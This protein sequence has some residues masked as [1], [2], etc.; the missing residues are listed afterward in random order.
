MHNASLPVRL[1]LLPIDL[2]RTVILAVRISL[3]HL[4]VILRSTILRLPAVHAFCHAERLT[5]GDFRI[6]ACPFARKFGNPAL[7]TMLCSYCRLTDRMGTKRI[8]VCHRRGG[9]PASAITHILFGVLPVLA[10]LAA[11]FWILRPG[12]GMLEETQRLLHPSDP[13][14]APLHGPPAASPDP[15]SPPDAST[16]DGAPS[17]PT[18]ASDEEGDI[19]VLPPLLR[20][21]HTAPG[22][23]ERRPPLMGST[24]QERRR[25]VEASASPAKATVTRPLRVDKIR[26]LKQAR[27]AARNGDHASAL[28]LAQQAIADGE[29]SATARLLVARSEL[30]CG[31][32]G[33][34]LASAKR[35]LQLDPRSAEAHAIVGEVFLGQGSTGLAQKS[36]QKALGIDPQCALARAGLARIMVLGLQKD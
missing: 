27:E 6:N 17:E 16:P 3:W 22:T 14:P 33:E 35:V 19:P 7:F 12:P 2:I 31:K 36:F 10:I 15:E 18:P 1:L 8:P 9:G 32:T 29:G 5:L 28:R 26:L 23:K 30:E 11:L 20:P 25:L 21:R 4:G 24:P 34:A 13:V